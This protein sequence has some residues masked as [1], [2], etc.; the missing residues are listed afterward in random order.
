MLGRGRMLLL[1]GGATLAV[2]AALPAWR[3]GGPADATVPTAVV[4]RAAFVRQIHAEGNLKAADATIL[5][6]PPLQR[7]PFKLA[8]LAPDGSAVHA[9]DVV[10][11]FD[12]SD[13]ETELRQGQFDA[14]TADSKISSQTVRGEGSRHNLVRDAAAATL[15]LHHAREFQSK[16]A[17]IFSR[18]Q[19][20]EAEIDQKLAE[21]K[22]EHAEASGAVHEHLAQ[23]DLGLLAIE[24]RQAALK[25][26]QATEALRELE[27]KAPHDGILVLKTQ[28]GGKPR[29]GDMAWGQVAEIPRPDRMQAEVFVLEADAGGLSVGLEG[30]VVIDA[31]PETEY[32]ARVSR[33]AALAQR[34]NQRVPVQYFNVIL[35][36]ERTEREVMKPGHR[37]HAVIELDAREGALTVPRQAVFEVEGRKVVYLERGG[38]FEPAGVE[39]GPAGPGRVVIESGLSEGDRVALRD[40]TRPADEPSE[41][42]AAPGSA[43]LG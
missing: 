25:I 42:E 40:P 10:I 14:A 24:R 30:R 33:V 20:V 21:Q 39:L 12:P 27:V 32:R 41:G 3:G 6:P 13:L 17:T 36:L 29:V 26:T 31:H 19:I 8:W 11:R 9:G 38:R 15:D 37:V 2:L 7:R 1:A 23:A 35:D 18:Q 43:P 5:G 22:K 34:R 4:E 28:W 16:D